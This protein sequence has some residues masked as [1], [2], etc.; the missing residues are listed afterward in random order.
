MVQILVEKGADVAAQDKVSVLYI[1]IQCIY[2][3]D[4]IGGQH[5]ISNVIYRCVCKLLHIHIHFSSN[6]CSMYDSVHVLSICWHIFYVFLSLYSF[7][8]EGYT[9]LHLKETLDTLTIVQYLAHNGA[10]VDTPSKVCCYACAL[11]CIQWR[12]ECR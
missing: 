11:L 10:P 8:Q 2:M 6:A 7:P 5:Q 1:R 4:F 3:P 12:E 9:C